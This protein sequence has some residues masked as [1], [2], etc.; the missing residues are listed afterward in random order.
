M[1]NRARG[2]TAGEG[3][4]AGVPEVRE[5]APE[6]APGAPTPHRL[7][8]PD[9]EAAGRQRPT[10]EILVPNSGPW[11]RNHNKIS[12]G[13]ERQAQVPPGLP[14]PAAQG[15]SAWPFSIT[16][17]T[18]LALSGEHTGILTQCLAHRKCSINIS[19]GHRY[20]GQPFLD[21]FVTTPTL[22]QR[23]PRFR[24]PCGAPEGPSG[25]AH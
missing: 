20:F 17:P 10:S 23:L 22:R 19:Y 18:R 9:T 8:L 16:A 12:P 6:C 14:R 4:R 21:P 11:S 24:A 13:P 2:R 3:T 1:P 15:A 25:G 5:M 7:R